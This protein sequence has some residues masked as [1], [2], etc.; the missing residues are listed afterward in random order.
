MAYAILNDLQINRDIVY[1]RINTIS[2]L[3]LYSIRLSV[4][5][6]QQFFE[7]ARVGL[8]P[9]G[10]F[11]SPPVCSFKFGLSESRTG[12]DI[13]S[14]LIPTIMLLIA[15]LSVFHSNALCNQV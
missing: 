11:G 6:L 14:V 7:H 13:R 9:S 12:T 1:N 3:K 2:A 8:S 4:K 5:Y 10:D 15:D